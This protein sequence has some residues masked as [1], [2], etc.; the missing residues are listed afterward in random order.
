MTYLKERY[1][2]SILDEAEAARIQY[3]LTIKEL[4]EIIERCMEYC[5]GCEHQIDDPELVCPGHLVTAEKLAKI[6]SSLEARI[7]ELEK[8]VVRKDRII[9]DLRYEIEM[10]GGG[11]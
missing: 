3:E 1:T 2:K 4:R 5:G 9:A 7:L 11:A 8:M 6:E 10:L